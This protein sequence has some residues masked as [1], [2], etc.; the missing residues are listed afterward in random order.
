MQQRD[1][2][3]LLSQMGQRLGTMFT[4]LETELT[5]KLMAGTV[6]SA[7]I[8]RE[9]GLILTFG[10]GSVRNL[11]V[12]L[13]AEGP[14]GLHGDTG[15]AGVDGIDG[16]DGAPGIDGID[17]KDGAPGERGADA[18]P[19]ALA[20]LDSRIDALDC[21][22]MLDATL[23]DGVLVIA[24]GDGTTRELG[25]VVGPQGPV[26]PAGA[27]GSATDVEA[28]LAPLQ[29]R[30]E[31]I[32]ARSLGEALIDR[33]G[34]LVLTFA[35]GTSQR[36]G[37]VV[38]RDGIDGKDGVDGKDGIDG[39]DGADGKLGADGRD[40]VDGKPGDPGPA[41]FGFDDLDV[42]MGEDG[43]TLRLKFERGEIA[44]TFELDFPVMIYRGV[45]K[46]ETDYVRGDAVTFGGS[47]F[48][49]AADTTQSRPETEGGAWTLAVKR[50]R[51]GKDFAGPR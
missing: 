6:S 28:A 47:V 43:R 30:L 27:D 9:G 21:R 32:E 24:L 48:V 45:Y 33:Q 2:D 18:D 38:G 20:L 37:E 31:G 44:Q 16:K 5:A 8:D 49:C 4:R 25:P 12:V 35:D 19:I 26:G 15:P 46:P 51:D 23:T 3:G 50:G 42:E 39:K 11:G 13:G 17:G 34:T 14:V 29:A 22:A 7:L 41:G 1:L 40:G 36:V 10:D